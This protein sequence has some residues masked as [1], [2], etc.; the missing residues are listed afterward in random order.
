MSLISRRAIAAAVA[1]LGIFA[2]MVLATPQ[3]QA[4]DKD[5]RQ[6]KGVGQ[7]VR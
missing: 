6:R 1:F 7:G 3:A 2:T 4:N 5:V